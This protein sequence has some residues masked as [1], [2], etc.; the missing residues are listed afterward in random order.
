MP[1]WDSKGG[2]LGGIGVRHDHEANVGRSSLQTL[3]VNAGCG[4]MLDLLPGG[5]LIYPGEHSLKL[6]TPGL[7]YAAPLEL[8]DNDEGS[9]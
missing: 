7:Y 8:K 3:L 2:E 9:H 4:K 1:H 5:H 6:G